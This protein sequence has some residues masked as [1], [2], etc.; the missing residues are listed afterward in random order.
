MMDRERA[1]STALGKGLAMPHLR[2]KAVSRFVG[3]VGL[4]PDGI[5]FQS[6]DGGPT[7]LVFLVLGPYEQRE[8]HF[9]LMGRIS[10]FMRD[11]ATLMFLQGHRARDEIH[12]FLADLDARSGEG[13]P[14]HKPETPKSVIPAYPTS[15]PATSANPAAAPP[16]LA[17]QAHLEHR[18]SF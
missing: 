4:A 7:K 16:D 2:T 5:D 8:S 18:E 11:K 9:E 3:A 17:P 15:R 6:I 10:A 13:A 12:H 1:G 14:T